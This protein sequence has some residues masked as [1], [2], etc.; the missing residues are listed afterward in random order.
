MSSS[1]ALPPDPGTLP[2]A[3]GTLVH[4]RA[5]DVKAYHVAPD[6][7]R[8]RGSVHDVK[9]PGMYIEDDPDPLSVHH[10]EVDLL[11]EFPSLTIV[12]A[13]VAMNVTPHMG[14]NTIEPDYQT[15]VGLSIARGF[16]R[17]VKDLF[18]GPNGCTHIGALLQAMAPVAIQS[19]WSMR[20]LAS[21]AHPDG[22]ANSFGPEERKQALAFNLNTCHIWD[23]NG[24]QVA[25]ML[26]GAEM[27]IPVWAVKRLEAMGRSPEEWRRPS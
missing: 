21:R 19:G 17:Q 6:R 25:G 26:A 27:E 14:C 16:S 9:P 18:G 2:A 24:A 10:M 12:E 7:L 15:L 8:L 22:D 20:T 3:T 1:T 11:L 13:A 23:E 5:Y 4:Q